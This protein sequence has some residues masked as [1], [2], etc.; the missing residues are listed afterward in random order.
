M[1][2]A[3]TLI[4]LMVAMTLSLLLLLA[5][6]KLFQGVGDTIN[7]TQATLNM[8]A[9]MTNVTIT[10]RND[11]DA[12]FKCVD[13]NKPHKMVNG[14]ETEDR[15]YL[16][17]IEGDNTINSYVDESNNPDTT[18]GDVNDILMG[19][20]EVTGANRKYRGLVNNQVTESNFAEIIW[21]V[22][23]TTL[24]RQTKLIIDGDS[25]NAIASLNSEENDVSV[26]FDGTNF[27][28]NKLSHLARRE[29]RFAYRY[30]ALTGLTNFPFPHNPIYR[31]LRLPTM[32]E[33]N[34][35]VVPDPAV[36]PPYPDDPNPP[37]LT[38]IDLWNNPN[39]AAHAVNSAHDIT[40]NGNGW[41]GSGTR[42]GED[43]V[44]TNVISFDI[45]VWNP[46]ANAFVDLG[47]GSANT[48]DSQGRYSGRPLSTDIPTIPD[49]L[50]P[51]SA[52]TPHQN[53]IEEN[54]RYEG[55]VNTV[56]F[57]ENEDNTGTRSYDENDKLYKVDKASPPNTIP[58]SNLRV[59]NAPAYVSQ[60]LPLT[61][62][63]ISRWSGP[64]MPRV[65]DTWTMAYENEL[66]D[67]GSV[68]GFSNATEPTTDVHRQINSPS[69]PYSLTRFELVTFDQEVHPTDGT[70]N[71]W[72]Y[73]HS[74]NTL[75][76][77]V[78]A[79][80]AEQ[81]FDSYRHK[82]TGTFIN[83]GSGAYWECPPPYDGQLKGIEITI[84]CFDPKSGNI[85][86][87]RV[88]KHVRD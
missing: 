72:K 39:Y 55:L 78:N 82:G 30:V 67:G 50:F 63:L 41:I 35:F 36:N 37:Y 31:E 32:A 2:R 18:I 45:K 5:V 76:P 88:V 61:T 65:F 77:P 85:R 46:S 4:E 8:A 29:N 68:T 49:N 25:N 79:P 53:L 38:T 62:L 54:L 58:L 7:D 22:R 52:L 1:K 12:I 9:N 23:G 28:L 44:L 56:Y 6:A 16:E 57:D 51:V 60:D 17:I 26:R 87:V 69:H 83:N 20:G 81:Y 10:L 73:K 14:E 59:D 48:F 34:N 70:K 64:P 24:Y 84:R 66:H 40:A 80:I 86:Q 11:L 43:V 19:T 3:F 15:G 33:L 71:K 74:L 13:I 75:P 21:F 47:N 42:A 27:Y